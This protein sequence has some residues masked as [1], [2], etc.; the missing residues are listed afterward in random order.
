MPQ[1]LTYQD[2]KSKSCDIEKFI[3]GAVG[4]LKPTLCWVVHIKARSHS[5]F[6]YMHI[7]SLL[8][9]YQFTVG[10]TQSDSVAGWPNGDSNQY[11]FG[12]YCLTV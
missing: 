1:L 9:K 6:N 3:E 12:R 4:V 8:R 2:L 10:L 5:S 7:F 11:H